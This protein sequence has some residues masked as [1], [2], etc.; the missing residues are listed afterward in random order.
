M[1]SDALTLCENTP[2]SVKIFSMMFKKIH[3]K[4]LVKFGVIV[5][6]NS[7]AASVQSW[8]GY[9]TTALAV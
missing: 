2:N 9:I 3:L 5:F 8:S 4:S 6:V 7:S 1:I